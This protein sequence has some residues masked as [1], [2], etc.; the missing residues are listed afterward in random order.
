MGARSLRLQCIR[1]FWGDFPSSTSL[2]MIPLLVLALFGASAAAVEVRGGSLRYR[3]L[4]R[5]KTIEREEILSAGVV[6]G[7]V[8]GAVRLKRQSSLGQTVFCPRWQRK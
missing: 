4:F 7:P 2:I 1:D 3:Q 5:W 8:L 6:W